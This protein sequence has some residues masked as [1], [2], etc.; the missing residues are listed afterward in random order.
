MKCFN[1]L[2]T[3]LKKLLLLW[4]RFIRVL[5]LKVVTNRLTCCYASHCSYGGNATKRLG[6]PVKA[7]AQ[8]KRVTPLPGC[9]HHSAGY[10]Q[11]LLTPAASLTFVFRVPDYGLRLFRVVVVAGYRLL[12]SSLV[13]N[14]LTSANSNSQTI[15]STYK[16]LRMNLLSWCR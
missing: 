10:P 6:C 12:S 15:I 5:A 16:C 3:R 14:Y 9:R 2:L 1:V 8:C 4:R 11:H 13:T 7:S